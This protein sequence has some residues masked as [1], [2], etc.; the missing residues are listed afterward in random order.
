MRGRLPRRWHLPER[1]RLHRR[2]RLLSRA[3]RCWLPIWARLRRRRRPELAWPG[4]R[5][6][7][8]RL[9]GLCGRSWARTGFRS[10]VAGSAPSGGR[11]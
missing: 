9:P 4:L 8:R 3:R 7:V 1:G 5:R 11:R 2:R 6:R 10:R